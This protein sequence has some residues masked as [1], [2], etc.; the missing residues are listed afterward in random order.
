ML[1]GIFV[2]AA[3]K[4]LRTE[5]ACVSRQTDVAYC[6]CSDIVLARVVRGSVWRV[7]YFFIVDNGPILQ[8]RSVRALI[9]GDLVASKP[10]ARRN[11]FFLRLAERGWTRQAMGILSNIISR[12]TLRACVI[13]LHEVFLIHT[14][15]FQ[16]VCAQRALGLLIEAQS[17][18]S[19]IAR[20]RHHHLL[21]VLASLSGA[22]INH[23]CRHVFYG[24][25]NRP[26]VT[27]VSV[28]CGSTVLLAFASTTSG[29]D[30]GELRASSRLLTSI[31]MRDGL[32]IRTIREYL[33]LSHGFASNRRVVL[34]RKIIVAPARA[35]CSVPVTIMN[36]V[37]DLRGS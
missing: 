2:S 24:R 13:R 30:R 3:K 26:N 32:D 35:L 34:G 21:L 37:P 7:R 14:T 22:C 8:S 6:R 9:G 12:L 4:I 15:P 27:T 5:L 10:S 29:C 18:W 20:L 36:L 1:F 17:L 11:C 16:L 31:L 28:L 23:R 25:V 19:S 33:T